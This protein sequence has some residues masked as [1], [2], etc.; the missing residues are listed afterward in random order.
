MKVGFNR[1][2]LV[3]FTG[4]KSSPYTEGAL[5]LGEKLDRPK[6][7]EVITCLEAQLG[8]PQRIEGLLGRSR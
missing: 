3:N 5:F 7:E 2:G 1:A 8:E 6:T 4:F